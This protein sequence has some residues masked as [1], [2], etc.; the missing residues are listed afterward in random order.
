M[1]PAFAR[2]LGGGEYPS[3]S[4]A[5]EHFEDASFGERFDYGISR[6]LGV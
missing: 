2:R 4:R 3:L 5:A 1:G 6:I